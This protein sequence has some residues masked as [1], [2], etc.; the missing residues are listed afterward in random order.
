M[1][2]SPSPETLI[3]YVAANVRRR[4]ERL[5]LTQEELAAAAEIDLTYL[6]RIERAS[7]NPSVRVLA[8]LAQAL[9][10]APGLLLRKREP[11]PRRKA[12]RPKGR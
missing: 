8:Q 6:Q 1:P 7:A 4:R 9:D 11:L 12:G 10:L 3:G 5:G 2:T